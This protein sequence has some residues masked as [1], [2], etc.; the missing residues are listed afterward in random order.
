MLDFNNAV[1]LGGFRIPALTTRRTETAIELQNG[2]TFAI[3]G[4]MNNSVTSTLSKIPGIGDIPILGYLFRS[5]AARK[6]QT[7]L[8]V[9][10]TPQILPAGS[11]GVTA[12]LPRQQEPY[13]PPLQERIS[14][15]APPPAFV[16]PP[17]APGAALVSP[18]VESVLPSRRV[19]AVDGKALDK[20]AARQADR[21]RREAK[22]QQQRQEQLAREQAKQ[23]A[24]A[25]K[26]AAEAAKR[27]AEA[28]KR[29]AEAARE[30]AERERKRQAAL[31]A[32]AARV[33]AAQ[34]AYEAQLAAQRGT[35]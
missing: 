15:P 22:A 4:L 33:R 18:A 10:I 9:I 13:L 35:K 26:R 7:E 32:A 6:D 14:M 31:D 24:E 17:P 21:D 11:P 27:D 19:A 30:Q 20:N 1:T 5:K 2:Q 29:D 12:S 3:A 34:D 25:A 16:E 8:V 28:A 23:E